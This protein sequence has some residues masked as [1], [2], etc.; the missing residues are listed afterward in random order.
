[1][2][3]VIVENLFVVA[4][5]LRIQND[6]PRI[7]VAMAIKRLVENITAEDSGRP[8]PLTIDEIFAPQHNQ[9]K[10]RSRRFNE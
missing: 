2:L 9:S 10:K 6:T 7:I 5:H 3:G 8:L 4:R 1:M